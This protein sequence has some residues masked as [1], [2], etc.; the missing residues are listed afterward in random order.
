MKDFW[1]PVVSAPSRLVKSRKVAIPVSS[2]PVAGQSSALEKWILT[3]CQD[4]QVPKLDD[5]DD[6]VS[7]ANKEDDNEKEEIRENVTYIIVNCEGSYFPGL[8]TKVKKQSYQVSC[9]V[10]CGFKQ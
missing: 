1:A 3:P 6:G 10:K 2:E 4:N 9:M 7:V 5:D 8:I